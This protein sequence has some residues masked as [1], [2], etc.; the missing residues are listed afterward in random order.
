MPY[1]VVIRNFPEFGDYYLSQEKD[2]TQT[3]HYSEALLAQP[4]TTH[5]KIRNK[6][7][8]NQ[9]NFNNLES[10]KRS[11]PKGSVH[12]SQDYKSSN[13]LTEDLSSYLPD[14]RKNAP[15]NNTVTNQPFSNNYKQD[16][17]FTS[18]STP[19]N[20]L[21]SS[22]NKVPLIINNLITAFTILLNMFNS[23]TSPNKADM[24][25]NFMNNFSG[26]VTSVFTFS[27]EL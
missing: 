24:L 27:N 15:F 8:A 5:V 2:S 12:F 6:L 20:L 7:K 21:S 22:H 4:V 11:K 1:F 16:N 17:S 10:R 9:R 23:S 14:I 26:N 19:H 3:G 25:N 18:T 13:H